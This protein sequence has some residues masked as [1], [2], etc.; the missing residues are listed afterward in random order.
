MVMDNCLIVKG[1][2]APAQ[3]FA[4]H[5]KHSGLGN[6]GLWHFGLFADGV[7]PQG[8]VSWGVQRHIVS[9][10]QQRIASCRFMGRFRAP[11][12]LC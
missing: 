9:W 2:K 5:C 4:G 8:L 3:K 1:V 7:G 11:M 6:S 10:S 12:G